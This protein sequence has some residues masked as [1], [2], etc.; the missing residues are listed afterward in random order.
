MRVGLTGSPFEVS[1]V[2]AS[3]LLAAMIGLLATLRR[4]HWLTTLVFSASFLS[5]A[6]VPL[7]IHGILHADSAVT[8]GSWANY[9]ARTS[10]LASGLRCS[11]RVVLGWSQPGEQTEDSAD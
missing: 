3:A 10:A 2:M 9:R 8:A 5:V 1:I 6:A 7:G 4:G 11:R